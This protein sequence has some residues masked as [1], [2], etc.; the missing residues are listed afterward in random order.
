M[1]QPEFTYIRDCFNEHAT[2]YL[3]TV[4]TAEQEVSNCLFN[5]LLEVIDVTKSVLQTLDQVAGTEENSSQQVYLVGDA[6]STLTRIMS[7]IY[8]CSNEM[9]NVLSQQR[10]NASN[11]FEKCTAGGSQSSELLTETDE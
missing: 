3:E 6:Q 10:F 2:R 11:A 5:R 1:A 4:I 9:E 7:G 8:D